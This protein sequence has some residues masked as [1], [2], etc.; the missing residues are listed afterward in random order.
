[1]WWSEF[2]GSG[3]DGRLTMHGCSGVNIAVVV[4]MALVELVELWWSSGVGGRGQ[5]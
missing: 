3:V 4:I 5:V 2:G 1:M